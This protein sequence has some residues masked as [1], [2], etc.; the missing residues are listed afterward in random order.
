MEDVCLCW[1]KVCGGYR[2]RRHDGVVVDG[3]VVVAAAIE[4]EESGK[5]SDGDDYHHAVEKRILHPTVL[6]E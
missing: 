6:V 3:V 1:K 2:C 5:K 4:E